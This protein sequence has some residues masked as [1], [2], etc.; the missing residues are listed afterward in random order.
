MVR[1]MDWPQKAANLQRKPLKPFRKPGER[2]LKNTWKTTRKSGSLETKHNEI[3][4]QDFCTV[5]CK[6]D[7]QGNVSKIKF[8]LRLI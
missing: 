4:A 7:I 3:M 5:L 1:H 6:S 8:K 2:L